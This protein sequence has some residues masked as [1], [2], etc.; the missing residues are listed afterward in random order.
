MTA[1]NN[2]IQP[3]SGSTVH[4]GDTMATGHGASGVFRRLI[5]DVFGRPRGHARLGWLCDNVGGRVSGTDSGRRAEEWA[6]QLL[7]ESHLDVRY[8]ELTVPVWTRGSLDC[9]VKEPQTWRMSA[10]AHGN[11]PSRANLT[12]DVVY[13]RH[14]ER[15]DFEQ[16]AQ[17]VGGRLALCDEGGTEGERVLHRSEK[18]GLA[19][20]FGAVGLLIESGAP[21]HL[22]RTGVCH[23]SVA[24]IPSIGISREDGARLRRLLTAGTPPRVTIEMSN[25]MTQG[26]ARNVLADLGGSEAPDEIVLAGAHLDS[27]DVAEGA[28]DNGLGCAIVLEMAR[29]LANLEVRPRR[30]LRFALWAAEETGLRGSVDYTKRHEQA[31]GDH[32]AVMNFDMTGAPIGFWTPGNP[33]PAPLISSLAE[34][35]LPLGIAS[36]VLHR[37][38]LHSDHQPFMLAGVPI[39]CFQSELREEGAH[40]YHSTGDTFDKVSAR[41][42]CLAAAAGALTMWE[43]S[44]SDA[45]PYRHKSP[46]EVRAMIDEARLY[47]ALAAEG[48]DGPPMHIGT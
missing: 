46:A 12:A 27:W 33:Q 47:G 9:T 17:G 11:S 35:L 36:P 34:R 23:G 13:V 31:L 38:R 24:P 42:L 20:E 14:G 26:V 10:L 41:D 44:Q 7:S 29:V 43:L 37:A 45:R 22:P 3:G 8:E 18:L 6:Y 5:G 25:P 1:P 16:A 39:V 48:Y 19:V 28:T 30:T 15:P 21:G 2:T 4:G 40:F 32:V